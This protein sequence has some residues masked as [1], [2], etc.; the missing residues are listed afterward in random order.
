V[1][2]VIL[3]LDGRPADWLAV[4]LFFPA[5]M[6]I[7]AIA[8]F[9]NTYTDI[10]EDQLYFPSS[11][12]ITGDLSISTAKKAFIV[13]NAIAGSLLISIAVFTSE[14]LAVLALIVC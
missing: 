5:V 2:A 9:A 11:P 13:Q 12:F 14:F 3:G 6:I 1:G 10:K 8:E 7:M 4:G